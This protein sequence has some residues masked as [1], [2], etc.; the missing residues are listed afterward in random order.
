V[1]SNLTDLLCDLGRT[2]FG[3]TNLQGIPRRSRI[4]SNNLGPLCST[5]AVGTELGHVC[6]KWQII[7]VRRSSQT[8]SDNA[9]PPAAGGTR[10]I[11]TFA[12]GGFTSHP[13]DEHVVGNFFHGAASSVKAA[14][15][16]RRPWTDHRPDIGCF[17]RRITHPFCTSY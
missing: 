10:R 1:F 5:C 12:P 2:Q 4:S 7:Y 6:S 8:Q 16:P 11:R 9:L 13:Y 15:M 14:Q 17:R 3:V